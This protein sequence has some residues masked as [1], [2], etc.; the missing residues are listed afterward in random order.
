M[1]REPGLSLPNTF[2][3]LGSGSPQML[4]DRVRPLFYTRMRLGEFDP[5]AMNPY[6]SLDLSVVQSPEHRN[7]SLEAAVKSFVLLKN[8]R[9]TLPLQAQDLSRQ[10][11]AV[12]PCTVVGRG[13][14]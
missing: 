4:R 12:S 6:S 3:V 1:G 5:P 8:V 9:G 11:L 10:H 7:L 2:E 13:T 14:C